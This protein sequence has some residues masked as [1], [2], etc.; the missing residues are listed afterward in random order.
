M[1]FGIMYTTTVTEGVLG[2]SFPTIEA[3]VLDGGPQYDN[4]PILLVNQG[5]I[6]SA[7]FS[8]WLNN[9][10]GSTGVVLF[11]GVDTDKLSK[12]LMIF[13]SDSFLSRC[14]ACK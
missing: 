13:L 11:G 2:V 6:Q 4:L 10:Q 12:G 8:V 5:Y 3:I 9:D 1:E 7:A 14:K